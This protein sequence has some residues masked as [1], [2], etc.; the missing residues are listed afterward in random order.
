MKREQSGNRFGE[1]G[2]PRGGSWKSLGLV[3]GGGSGKSRISRSQVRTWS[4]PEVGESGSGC[5]W[6]GRT[7]DVRI[8]KCQVLVE[9]LGST[10][11]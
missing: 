3:W 9:G 5:L 4:D 10:E 11:G 1:L 2:G 7:W 8:S 6:D